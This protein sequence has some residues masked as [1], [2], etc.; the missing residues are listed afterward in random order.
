MWRN[1]KKLLFL[2][3]LMPAI[4]VLIVSLARASNQETRSNS[5]TIA[6][7]KDNTLYEDDEGTLSNGSGEHFFT[8]KA[9]GRVNDGAIRRGLIA[10]ESLAAIPP[11]SLILNAELILHMSR[12]T[13]GTQPVTLHKIQSNWGE[14]ASD[15][16]GQ[17]GGGTSAMLEDATWLHSFFADKFWQTPGGDFS[18][19]SSASTM[20]GSVG[21][22]I[23]SGSGVTNDVRGWFDNPD[24]NFGWILVNESSNKTSKRFDSRENGTAEFRPKLMVTY[25]PPEQVERLFLPTILKD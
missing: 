15:A 11:G 18:A 21:S 20:V 12:G 10:F 1:M 6:A 5:V 9:S 24:N 8:G 17:E 2:I 3:T 14:G 7:S 16:P 25:V 4:L 23:W 22:Y 13:S 19:T